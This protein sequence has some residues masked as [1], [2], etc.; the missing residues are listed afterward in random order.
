MVDVAIVGKQMEENRLHANQP[1]KLWGFCEVITFASH[2]GRY[3][4]NP[5]RQRY[6]HVE[7]LLGVPGSLAAT[8][9]LDI[10]RRI[11]PITRRPIL[12]L[13]CVAGIVGWFEAH[14]RARRDA[15]LRR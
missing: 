6:L 3:F 12:L 1:Q 2:K 5:K 9:Q 8:K 13:W 15:H 7:F 14:S 11:L 4:S 10:L